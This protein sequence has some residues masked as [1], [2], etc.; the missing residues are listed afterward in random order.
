MPDLNLSPVLP[1]FCIFSY[2]FVLNLNTHSN[3][4]ASGR[5][6]ELM[7]VAWSPKG[8]YPWQ[9]S[10]ADGLA[11][12]TR[13]APVSW[14]L[15]CRGKTAFHRSSPKCRST[16]NDYRV[17]SSSGYVGI[18]ICFRRISNSSPAGRMRSSCLISSG[19]LDDSDRSD[20]ATPEAID[21][22]LL[23]PAVMPL[24]FCPRRYGCSTRESNQLWSKYVS[25]LRRPKT[26]G[27]SSE[28]ALSL[29]PSWIQTFFTL[30]A[31]LT[32]LVT[33]F[34]AVSNCLTGQIHSPVVA[35]TFNFG[36]LFTKTKGLFCSKCK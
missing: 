28:K 2:L 9:L 7:V 16:E 4:H 15:H 24:F 22:F 8:G 29:W 27:G 10:P 23:Y 26:E 19:S 31:L 5:N 35:L 21:F 34:L 17:S 25:P 36:L 33:A 12:G 11:C 20:H 6:Y 1:T 18:G 13:I 14:L 3:R 30:S 32:V